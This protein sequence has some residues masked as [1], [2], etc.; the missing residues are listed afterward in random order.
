M[1]NHWNLMTRISLLKTILLTQTHTVSCSW[2]GIGEY[3]EV[4]YDNIMTGL[5]KRIGGKG[6]GLLRM[7]SRYLLVSSPDPC[8]KKGKGLV[9][10]LTFLGCADSAFT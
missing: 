2:K 10:L 3:F 9:T 6:G 4:E 5:C 1:K 7:V 8:H